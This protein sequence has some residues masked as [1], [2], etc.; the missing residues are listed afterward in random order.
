MA[1]QAPGRAASR[2]TLFAFGAVSFAYFAYAGLFG[3]C[4]PL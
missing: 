3:T 2:R 1:A 4:A